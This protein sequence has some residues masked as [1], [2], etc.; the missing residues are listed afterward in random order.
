[1][2]A[3][4]YRRGGVWHIPFV[5]RR[6]DLP[7]HPGQIGLPGGGVRSGEAAW[8]AAAREAEEELAVPTAALRPLGAGRPLYAAVTNYCVVPFVAWLPL[9]EVRFRP[10]RRELTAVLEVPLAELLDPRAWRQ[11]AGP[12]PGP[13]FPLGEGMI[14]GLTARLLADLLPRISAAAPDL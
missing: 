8:E 5:A 4:L 11:G 13:H 3:I 1:M 14:W 7:D 9:S 12:L 6:P 10:D 2:T